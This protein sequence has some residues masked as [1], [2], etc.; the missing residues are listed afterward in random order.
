MIRQEPV[1]Q[2]TG[3]QSEIWIWAAVWGDKLAAARP[4][5]GG[6]VTQLTGSPLKPQ[7]L[8]WGR[9]GGSGCRKMIWKREASKLNRDHQ[10][11]LSTTKSIFVGQLPFLFL[12]LWVQG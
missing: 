1:Y 12:Q 3:F 2:P 6:S 11:L 7:E 9:R 5:A 10:N 4:P 8:R